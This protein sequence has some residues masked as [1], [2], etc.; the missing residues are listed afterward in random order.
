M[1]GFRKS[2]HICEHTVHHN[3]RK[4]KCHMLIIYTL[5]KSEY[6]SMHIAEDKVL[7]HVCWISTLHLVSIFFSYTIIFAFKIYHLYKFKK[8]NGLEYYNSTF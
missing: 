4:I 1:S 2:G 5:Q 6:R 7:K 3:Q 8:T